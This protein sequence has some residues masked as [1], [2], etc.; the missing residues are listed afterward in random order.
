[1]SNQDQIN[2]GNDTQLNPKANR[3]VLKDY[4]T[5][6]QNTIARFAE[7]VYTESSKHSEIQ[8]LADIVN[9]KLQAFLVAQNAYDIAKSLHNK[10][11][12]IMAYNHLIEAMDILAD[13]INHIS[14][15]IDFLS[16]T[17]FNLNNNTHTAK[18]P[19]PVQSIKLLDIMQVSTVKFKIIMLPRSYYVGFK[20][21]IHCEDGT[22][23]TKIR[24][25]RII[26]LDGLQ[27]GK[28]YTIKAAAWTPLS[29][30][31]EKYDYCDPVK[32][33]VQ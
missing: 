12:R 15:E 20:V 33:I 11:I 4:H 7:K 17:G 13:D 2:T 31:Q 29:Q 1:M 10:D 21:K 16:S 28:S 23:I 6:S 18:M 26:T 19:S 8:P 9:E 14:H 25:K 5:L 32:V 30:E 27:S 22:E 24:T 3:F